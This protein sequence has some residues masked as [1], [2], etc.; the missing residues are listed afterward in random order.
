MGRDV[1]AARV[2]ADRTLTQKDALAAE[3]LWLRRDPVISWSDEAGQS[4]DM[5]IKDR[6]IVGTAPSSDVVLVDRAISRLHAE[7]DPRDDGLWVRDL[8]SRNGTFLE[9]IR[10]VA[11]RIPQAGRLQLGRTELT[12]RYAAEPTPVDSLKSITAIIAITSLPMSSI[13]IGSSMA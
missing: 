3:A 10:V 7:L 9:G 2:E 8:E 6:V 4:R 11:A 1:Y 13:R 12:V 5:V